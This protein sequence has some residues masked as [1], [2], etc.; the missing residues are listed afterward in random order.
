[1]PIVN[2][3]AMVKSSDVVYGSG[4]VSSTYSAVTVSP[5]ET[6]R[7]EPEVASVEVKNTVP[8]NTPVFSSVS[9][10]V[11]VKPPLSESENTATVNV[12]IISSLMFSSASTTVNTAEPPADA[13][14]LSKLASPIFQ[15]IEAEATTTTLS[16]YS[17]ET[18]TP[19]VCPPVLK[20]PPSK[21]VPHAVAATVFVHRHLTFV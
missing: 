5:S 13:A 17:Y 2:V 3:P 20:L 16:L 7:F 8:S 14:L 18:D 1:M 19:S 10:R 4:R 21:V 15:A 6:R 12:S 11:S 9:F